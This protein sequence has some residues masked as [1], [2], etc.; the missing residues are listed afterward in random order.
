MSS[1]SFVR[2]SI[3]LQARGLSHFDIKC[4]QSVFLRLKDFVNSPGIKT[5]SPLEKLRTLWKYQYQALRRPS[6]RQPRGNLF[7]QGLLVCKRGERRLGKEVPCARQATTLPPMSN[8]PVWKLE[9]VRTK[10]KNTKNRPTKGT[11]WGLLP[12]GWSTHATQRHNKQPQDTIV[13]NNIS[14]C[15]CFHLWFLWGQAWS[16]PISTFTAN[17]WRGRGSSDSAYKGQSCAARPAKQDSAKRA[18][19]QVVLVSSL[20]T[21]WSK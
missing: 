4:H 17:A 20:T 2:L 5:G 1:A 3:F 21:S 14:P 11:P 15:C 9:F 13:D 16:L 12:P 7:P 8:L 6:S 10:N 19:G 18:Q